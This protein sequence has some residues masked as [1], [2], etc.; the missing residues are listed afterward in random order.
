MNLQ[1]SVVACGDLYRSSD[2]NPINTD[3]GARAASNTVPKLIWA[4][5]QSL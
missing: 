3:G 2:I 1:I 5:E 4:D